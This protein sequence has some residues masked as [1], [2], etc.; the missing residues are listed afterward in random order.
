MWSAL[1]LDDGTH[2]H[3]VNIQLPGTPAFSVGYVQD[4]GGNLTELQAVNFREAFGSNG[5]PQNTTLILKPGDITANID[6]RAHAPVRLN[7]SDWRV[8]HFPRAWVAVVTTDGRSG[9]GWME[10]NRNQV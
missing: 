1:H 4:S 5:L 10:W 3:G 8:S 2:L 6:V 7:A 9:V